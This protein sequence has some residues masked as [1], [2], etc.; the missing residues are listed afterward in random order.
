MDSTRDEK[1]DKFSCQNSSNSLSKN[2]KIVTSKSPVETNNKLKKNWIR[3]NVGGRIFMTSRLTLGRDPDSFLFRLCQ[4]DSELKTDVDE[5][6]AYMIDRDPDY[7]SPVLNYLRHGKLILN[8]DLN[9]EGVLEEAEFYNLACLVELI[10]HRMTEI[11]SKK[12]QH[13]AKNVY[14]VLQWSEEELAQMVS[15]ISDGWKFE[16]L[17]NLG[18]SYKYNLEDRAEFLCVVSKECHTSANDNNESADRGKVL[19]QR[20]S[21]I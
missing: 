11:N 5:S 8:N 2:K 21:R 4:E 17:I 13:H 19:Q 14:R 15:N 16:Q 7:F 1:A 10:K 6:G 20:A 9:Y 18:S 3:L 12:T